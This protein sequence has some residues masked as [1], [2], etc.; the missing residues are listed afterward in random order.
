MWPNTTSLKFLQTKGDALKPAKAEG[1]DGNLHVFYGNKL[2]NTMAPVTAISD[3]SSELQ[4][5]K[6]T[7]VKILGGGKNL[8]SV[9]SFAQCELV[10]MSEA[11]CHSLTSQITLSVAQFS[12][13]ASACEMERDSD[14]SFP[15]GDV[16]VMIVADA[17]FLTKYERI[18][19]FLASYCCQRDMQ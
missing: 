1:I 12:F 13:F 6:G 16:P 4:P 8:C 18:I 14:L 19:F 17:N 10:L 2:S 3:G 9:I 7:T 15:K 11:L 5:V